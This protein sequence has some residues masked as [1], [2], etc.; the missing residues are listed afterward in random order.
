MRNRNWMIA[1]LL[2]PGLLLNL[3]LQAQQVQ[4]K[5]PEA[6]EAHRQELKSRIPG[7][8][9][10]QIKQLEQVRKKHH[11]EHLELRAQAE[12]LHGQK[13]ALHERERAE[14]AAFLNEEQLKALDAL[15][16]EKHMQ[17]RGKKGGPH[18][19]SGRPE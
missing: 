8:T 6:R 16:K 12:K 2:V 14:A 17:N 15:L 3:N 7:I 5:G 1:M 9:D 11:A 4:K 10:E 19:E 13:K 18:P